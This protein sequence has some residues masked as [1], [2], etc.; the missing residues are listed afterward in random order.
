[1]IG[2]VYCPTFGGATGLRVWRLGRKLVEKLSMVFWR[3]GVGIGLC[4]RHPIQ[5]HDAVAQMDMVAGQTD[6][7]L[8][9]NGVLRLAISIHLIE[10]GLEDRL[11]EDDNVTAPGLT[12]MNKGHPLCGRSQIDAVNNQMIAN[13][14][15]IF[16]RSGWDDEVL[17]DEGE[18]EQPN[19]QHRTNAR[20]RF[21]GSFF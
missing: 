18:D 19:H 6:E 3:N 21:K 1:M 12:V 14:Q 16:H 7:A 4:L 15:R 2:K 5:D 11:V 17:R 20:Q 10:A 8:D 9:E 13:E